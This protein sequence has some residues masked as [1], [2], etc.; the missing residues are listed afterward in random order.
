[1]GRVLAVSVEGLVFEF[2]VGSSQRL[3]NCHQLLPWLAFTI[4]GLEHD[5]LAQW[6][7]KV[8]GWGIMFICG[9]VLRCAGTLKKK[10]RSWVWT[11]YSRS[12]NHCCTYM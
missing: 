7:F 5:W 8:N 4:K 11:N 12:D 3:K 6:Q 2:L 10:K 9:M 1:V